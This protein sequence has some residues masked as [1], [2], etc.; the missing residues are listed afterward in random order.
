M[1]SSL[2]YNCNGVKIQSNLNMLL[3]KRTITNILFWF[4]KPELDEQIARMIAF[5]LLIMIVRAIF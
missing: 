3:M 4:L 1:S 5:L 2:R